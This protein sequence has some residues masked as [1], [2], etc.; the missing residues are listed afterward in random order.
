MAR[1]S[2]RNADSTVIDDNTE[3][4]LD[5]LAAIAALDRAAEQL[6]KA[7]P[8]DAGRLPEGCYGVR[9]EGRI[10]GDITVGRAS[11]GQE[12]EVPAFGDRE[13]LAAVMQVLEPAERPRVAKKAVRWI[14][15]AAADP[16]ARAQLDATQVI[17]LEQLASA[18]SEQGMCQTRLVG[19]RAGSV[20]GKPSGCIAVTVNERRMEL[21]V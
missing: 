10:E 20:S 19:A 11:A 3:R 7:L 6:R 4:T 9:L 5:T 2:A 15:R 21:V 18:A 14:A 12:R 13:A 8:K 17:T 16:A 1:N